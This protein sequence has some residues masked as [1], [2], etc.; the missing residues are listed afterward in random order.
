MKKIGIL[1]GMGPDATLS[2]YAE[3]VRV[4]KKVNP[5]N[6]CPHIIINNLPQDNIFENLGDKV[7]V[8]IKKGILDLLKIGANVI[9]I[10]CNTAHLYVDH[11]SSDIKK[12]GALF[13]HLI[14]EVVSY[15]VEK[16]YEHVGLIST[17]ASRELYL[18]AFKKQGISC[19]L[20]SKN[21]QQK[22][23]IIINKVLQHENKEVDKQHIIDVSITLLEKEASV[24][25]LGCTELPILFKKTLP[26]YCISTISI[27][28]SAIL[29]K[30]ISIQ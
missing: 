22:I 21:E 20:P 16:K 5:F 17:L 2:T 28:A 23:N 9:G 7:S 12:S 3:I 24:V 26:K 29:K 14:E 10:S 6:P 19:I 11:F 1:G 15:C 8:E 13:I 4:S 18:S 25:I 27:L 30:Y